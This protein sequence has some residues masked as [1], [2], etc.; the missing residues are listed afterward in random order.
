MQSTSPKLDFCPETMNNAFRLLAPNRSSE[1][2]LLCSRR[3]FAAAFALLLISS[4]YKNRLLATD[5]KS[6][7]IVLDDAFH[8]NGIEHATIDV[9]RIER[10]QFFIGQTY[11]F[12]KFVDVVADSAQILEVRRLVL[13]LFP[14]TD[15]ELQG[16]LHVLL[17][18]G[19][20]L[21]ESDQLIDM[22]RGAIYTFASYHLILDSIPMQTLTL[23]T[24]LQ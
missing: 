6:F 22:L 18:F 16:F 10:D 2:Y 23:R 1:L 8:E 12:R 14:E 9:D 4:A 19:E 24:K 21:L 15:E 3:L 11:S 5:V 7:E 13:Q 17:H 20:Q